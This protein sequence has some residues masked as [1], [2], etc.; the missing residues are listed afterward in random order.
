MSVTKRSDRGHGDVPQGPVSADGR[1]GLGRRRP[2][3]RRLGSR[4]CRRRNEHGRHDDQDLQVRDDP[5]Q[6]QDRVHP[7]GQQGGLRVELPED[8]ARSPA[9]Q[10]G[11]DALGRTRCEPRPVSAP[12]RPAEGLSR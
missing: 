3:C 9:A 6:R 8:L 2:L 4:R 12:W 10:G 5:R 11:D 1:R 7:E